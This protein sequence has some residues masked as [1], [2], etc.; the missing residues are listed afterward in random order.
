MLSSGLFVV[1]DTGRG[2]QDNVAERSGR[3]QLLNPVLDLAE[4]NVESGGDDTALVDSS[5]KLDDNLAGSVVID[6]LEFSDVA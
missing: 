4:L 1:H 3:E 2:G 6:F 5:V